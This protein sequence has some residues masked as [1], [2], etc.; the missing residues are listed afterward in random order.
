M[1]TIKLTILC[2][3]LGVAGI[4]NAWADRGRHSHVGVVIGPYW[5]PSYYSPFPRYYPPYYPYSYYYPPVIIERPAPPVYIEQAQQPAP[6]A[7][8]AAAPT[9]Y[10]Y[11][12]AATNGY[13]PYVRECRGGWQ[14][15]SPLPP[16]LQ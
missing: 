9:N 15:V 7:P 5:G 16:G 3:L 11:Y 14:K 1:K 13:Y 12:C 10:W 2:L 4:G 6:P 8:A